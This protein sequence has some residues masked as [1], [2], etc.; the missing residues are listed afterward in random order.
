MSTSQI[1]IMRSSMALF[2]AAISWGAVLGEETGTTDAVPTASHA[3][4]QIMVE[5]ISDFKAVFAT[6]ESA[7]TVVA[8]ARIRGTVAIQ[9]VDEGDEVEAGAVVAVIVDDRLV[10]QVRALDARVSALQAEVSQA[11]SDRDRAQQLL[12]RGVIAKARFDETQTRVNVV[13]G[14]LDAARQERSVII[15]QQQEGNVLAPTT[16]V[17]LNVDTTKGSV[18]FAGEPIARIA[19]EDYI[20]R[21][22]LPERH[23]QFLRE[24]DEVRVDQAVLGP[25]VAATG[26]IRKV[27]PQIVDGRVVA[28]ATVEGLGSYFIGER[29][30]VWVSASER[31]V[32][33]VP[34]EYFLTLYG[35]DYVRV[36]QQGEASQRVA[37]QRG[38]T[39]VD[40]RIEVLSGLNDDDVI[41]TP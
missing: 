41:V 24:G 21:L 36:Q 7:D 19:S 28:D 8:R 14:Q 3:R 33:L 13:T 9:N 6:V 40:G 17:V 22:R 37:V 5:E 10:P 27:Y 34:P 12:E 31:Q 18:V 2:G 38:R 11:I 20:L 15:Q 30:R 1:W 23:A 16:G 26:L 29:I 39:H 35:V 32:I 25:S 4:M